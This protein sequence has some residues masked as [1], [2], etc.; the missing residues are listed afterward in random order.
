M[1]VDTW[2]NFGGLSALFLK[3]KLALVPLIINGLGAR[4]YDLMKE[5]KMTVP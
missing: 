2:I 3:R 5:A 4:K 1:F